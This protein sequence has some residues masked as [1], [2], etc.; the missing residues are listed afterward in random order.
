MS[1]TTTRYVRKPI[2]VEAIRITGHNIDE[3]AD[4]CQG[5][6]KWEESPGNK[7]TGKKY[8]RVR[9]VNPKNP[10]QT[11][12]F[13]GD[14]ILYTDKGYKVYTHKAFVLSFDEGVEEPVQDDPN[15][16]VIG[17]ECFAT[18]DG[19][20]LNWKGTNYVPQGEPE[21]GDVQAAVALEEQRG[22]GLQGPEPEAES[23]GAEETASGQDDEQ[24]AA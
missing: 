13:V 10:R 18:A 1:V 21:N 6:V 2:H 20:V 9:V 11:K 15:I 22:E 14:W 7:G 23:E 16:T 4:W 3:V 19:S 24:K 12:A 5:D 8:I 17:P